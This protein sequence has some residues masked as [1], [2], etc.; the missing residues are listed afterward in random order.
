[1]IAFKSANACL[2][3]NTISAMTLLSKWPLACTALANRASTAS[4]A[5]PSWSMNDLP[6]LSASNT[7]M[8]RTPKIR[9]T[10]LLPL[11]MPPVRSTCCSVVRFGLLER[12]SFR[13]PHAFAVASFNCWEL[14]MA[15]AL[16]SKRNFTLESTSSR[17]VV[18]FTSRTLP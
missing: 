12:I 8:P 7:G 11:P 6:T 5:E 9:A 14:S 1:M 16:F 17:M 10:V 15:T 3:L 18:S 4:R 2:S 13:S